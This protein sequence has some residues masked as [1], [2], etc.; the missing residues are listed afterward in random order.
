M[1]EPSG[2]NTADDAPQ[3][4]SGETLSTTG[5]FSLTARILLVNMLPL[6]LLGGGLFY[7]DSYR[8]QLIN[9]R[10]K[11]AR[12]EAQI[13]AEAL[14]G[15]SRERQEAL[16]VQIGKEQGMRLRMFDAEGRLWADS[17]EL[18][19]PSFTFDDISDD[20]WDQRFARWLDRTVDTI[21]AAEPVTD[22]V[23]REAKTADAWPELVRAREQGVSQVTLYDWADG[24][25][26]ITAAAPVGLNGAT[27][28][29]VRNAVDIT[30]TVRAAR[31]TLVTAVLLILFASAMLS[32][33]LARTIVTPLR[34]LATAAVKV[35]QGRERGVEVPRLPDRSDEIGL[36]ARAVSDMTAA[37]RH[38]ID[39]VDSFAADVAHEIKNPL[40]SLR[41]AIESLPKVND[42][43]TRRELE[44]IAIHDVRRI[45]RLV[46]EISDASR[47]DSEMSRATRERID[48]AELVRSIIGSRE[49]RAENQDH[50]IE[51]KTHGPPPVVLGVGARLERVIENLLDN[52]VSFSP[53]EAPIEVLVENDGACVS[54]TVCDS[55]PGIPE[56]SRE[57][58]FHRFHSV[59]PE[60]EDFG[61]HSGLGLA[62]ARAIAEAHDGSLV[63]EARSDGAQG[64]C[65]RLRLPA[66]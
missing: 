34:E 52:A 61:N 50:R 16:L 38:R 18:D 21:V 15:A 7:L 44:M 40:A 43:E 1:A 3:L 24:T 54:V 39:A 27:L 62:I 10:F 14:A 9:E 48:M 55:G 31:T 23:P 60:Q 11:L 49:H 28:L 20:T 42:E 5:R 57:K 56:E 63:A 17:F 22:Y 29:T 37:L 33:Y 65:I 47:I 26:V 59:R 6:L 35:R 51:L 30:A 41:S 46:T 32:L 13:T 25:P 19:E 58:V 12:I 4:S 45:D 66:A 36:L 64:A 2:S 8:T 53:P